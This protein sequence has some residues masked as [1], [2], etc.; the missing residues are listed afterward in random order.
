MLVPLEPLMD[1]ALEPLVDVPL[2]PPTGALGATPALLGT[3]PPRVGRRVRSNGATC[4]GAIGSGGRTS[5]RRTTALPFERPLARH[6][7]MNLFLCS[8]T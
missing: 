5:G 8:P 7:A 4:S 2:E 6:F 3:L 1:V